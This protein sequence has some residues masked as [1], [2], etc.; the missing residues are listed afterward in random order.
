MTNDER[1]LET[2][3]GGYFNQD[4][5]DD[6]PNEEAVV[7]A[8]LAECDFV[9]CVIPSA[10]ALRALVLGPYDEAELERRLSGELWCDYY[11]PGVGLTYRQWLQWLLDRF[12]R[13][14]ERRGGGAPGTK[15]DPAAR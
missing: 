4:W 12:E 11:P 1:E 15:P 2:L 3:L 9:K 14:I 5:A 8:F 6:Y 13:E 7:A 10:R